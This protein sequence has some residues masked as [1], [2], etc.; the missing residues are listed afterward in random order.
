MRNGNGGALIRRCHFHHLRCCFL[1]C[2]LLHGCVATSSPW[3]F[4]TL[5]HSIVIVR[6]HEFC[7]LKFFCLNLPIFPTP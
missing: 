5:L 3:H 6:A 1:Y 7:R 4:A 2:A